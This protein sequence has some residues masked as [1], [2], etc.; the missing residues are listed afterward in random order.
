V[1][2]RELLDTAQVPGQAGEMQLYRHDGDFIFRVHG[3]DLMTSRV[4]GSEELL[5]ELALARL[6][7]ASDARVLV[8]GLGMG[9]TLASVLGLVGA[10]ARV[11]VIELI[12]EVLA[13]NRQWLGEL[14][15]HPLRDARVSV[16]QGDVVRC[17]R[18]AG[19]DYD[20][21][22]LDVDNGPEA[23][24]RE[25]NNRIYSVRGLSAARAALRPGG[26]LAIWSATQLPWFTERFRN[27]RFDVSVEKVRARR[28]KGARQTIW[29]GTKWRG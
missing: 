6:S 22:L 3:A 7:D 9:F 14:A 12:P 4:H 17:I 5:A 24:T 10:Q 23:L 15:G 29:V 1:I 25:G 18:E 19:S 27:A 11:E 28:D 20:A 16:R 26:V 8:G 2:P 13:W 21:I